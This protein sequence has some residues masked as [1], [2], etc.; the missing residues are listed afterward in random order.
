VRPGK[1]T[2]VR[3][4][5]VKE[6]VTLRTIRVNGWG[7]IR[8]LHTFTGLDRSSPSA[9]RNW[10]LTKLW[11]GSMDAL[12]IG[13][14]LFVLSGLILAFARCE[15]RVG[16]AVALGFGLLVCGFFVFGLRWF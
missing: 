1:I 8:M 3:A 6:S 2:E 13:F 4:D 7:V 12:A 9:E 11:A 5:P 10:I 16:A 15:R 14:I